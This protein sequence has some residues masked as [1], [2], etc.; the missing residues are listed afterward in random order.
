MGKHVWLLWYLSRDHF[1]YL[2]AWAERFLLPKKVSLDILNNLWTKKTFPY[3]RAC[4]M[5][6]LALYTCYAFFNADSD[7]TS[8]MR[9]DG[10]RTQ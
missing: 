8:C 10:D 3:L 5:I 4:C 2:T 1:L 7:M 6:N 9:L